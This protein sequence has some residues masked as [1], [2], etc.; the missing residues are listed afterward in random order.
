MRA[1]YRLMP[2]HQALKQFSVAAMARVF[3]VTREGFY[4]WCRRQRRRVAEPRERH[5]DQQV[6]QKIRTLAAD[7]WYTDGVNRIYEQLQEWDDTISRRRVVRL[8]NAHVI[9]GVTRRRRV[10]TTKRGHRPHGIQDRVQRDFQA[11]P[12]QVVA[13]DASAIR[14]RG[15]FVYLAVTL[16]LYSRKVLGWAVSRHAD[17]NLMMQVLGQVLRRGE[18]PG[19]IHHSDQGSQ[20]TSRAF[21]QLC[22]QHGVLQSTGSVGDCYDNAVV[23]SFFA[24]L[25][26][27]WLRRRSFETMTELGTH[28]EQYIDEFYHAKRLHSTL[29]Y[30]SPNDY[31]ARFHQRQRTVAAGG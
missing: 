12:R 15:G 21:Q 10:S 13:S 28:L 1:I 8:M 18:C 3:N 24:T 5:N 22:Q 25:K 16:D 20:Y 19:L 9:Q 17:A 27:E 26:C 6:L 29:G 23:E 11:A 4:A 14:L 2:A 31:E 30:V 7:S